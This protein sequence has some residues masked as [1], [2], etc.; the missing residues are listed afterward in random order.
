MGRQPLTNLQPTLVRTNTS[1]T[2][3][4]SK[5]D[6]SSGMKFPASSRL[7]VVVE[8][9]NHKFLPLRREA[10]SYGESSTSSSSSGSSA[11]ESVSSHR[12]RSRY[13]QKLGVMGGP[14]CVV[15]TKLAQKIKPGAR[16]APTFTEVLKD[17]LGHADDNLTALSPPQ[18]SKY[19]RES[20]VGFQAQ[21]SI[22]EIPHRNE[23][24]LEIR[25]RLWMTP[26]ELEEAAYRNCIE[27]T[28]EEWDWRQAVE[29]PDF[30]LIQGVWTHPAHALLFLQ[31]Q[32]QQRFNPNRQFC[33]IFS[34]QQ[35]Q[36]RHLIHNHHHHGDQPHLFRPYPTIR[37]R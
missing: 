23:Y 36:Q 24:S 11:L 25:E 30:C 12:I 6:S 37:Y 8:S 26:K 14:P 19:N 29:E 17:D 4:S 2:A 9:S 28:A 3:T 22:H 18:H 35:Q 16:P 34:A 15:A 31:E 5:D 20:K 1:S 7:V 21:V 13:F 32:Q 27:F 33:M 10:S